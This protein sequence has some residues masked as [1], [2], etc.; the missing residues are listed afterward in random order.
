FYSPQS[1]WINKAV[2]G[3]ETLGFTGGLGF[4]RP[5]GTFSFTN[6]L[7]A[8]YGL[9]A[10][11]IFYFWL[12]GIKEIRKWL[13]ITSTF[14]LIIAIPISISRTLLFEV[15]ITAAFTLVIASRKPRM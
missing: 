13:L 9:A 14:A 2:G 1:A 12:V 11:F 5:S 15:G 8:Y 4:F 6:G 3:I 7:S 10:P